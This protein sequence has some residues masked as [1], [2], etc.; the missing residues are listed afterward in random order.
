MSSVNACE[1]Q[2][3][4]FHGVDIVWTVLWL[5]CGPRAP[6]LVSKLHGATG[7]HLRGDSE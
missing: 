5:L 4:V 3:Y 1:G 2:L 6:H 7:H